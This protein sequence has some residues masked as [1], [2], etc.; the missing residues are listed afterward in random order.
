MAENGRVQGNFR[1]FE[2]SGLVLLIVTRQIA[3]S[4]YRN[5]ESSN[6]FGLESESSGLESEI[7]EDVV[8]IWNPEG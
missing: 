8:G 6:F 7:Q 5:P 4:L 3:S 2:T 1:T